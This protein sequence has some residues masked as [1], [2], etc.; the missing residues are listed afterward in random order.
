M[1]QRGCH[2]HPGLVGA[3]DM[4]RIGARPSAYMRVIS[5]GPAQNL[6]YPERKFQ[7]SWSAQ[8][9]RLSRRKT[10]HCGIIGDLQGKPNTAVQHN[11]ELHETMTM[12]YRPSFVPPLR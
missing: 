10:G 5:I 6:R 9:A 2:R 3:T 1:F 4:A 8:A 12:R 7:V 11:S